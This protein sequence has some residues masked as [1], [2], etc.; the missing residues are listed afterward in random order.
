MARKETSKWWWRW[1]SP[2]MRPFRFTSSHCTLQL[3]GVT[4]DIIAGHKPDSCGRRARGITPA[5]QAFVPSPLDAKPAAP[6]PWR[7]DAHEYLYLPSTDYCRRST[8]PTTFADPPTAKQKKSIKLTS[9]ELH[10][11]NLKDGKNE[12]EFTVITKLQGKA[13]VRVCVIVSFSRGAGAV[14]C[15]YVRGIGK[16]RLPFLARL[17]TCRHH[18]HPAQTLTTHH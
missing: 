16:P 3:I 4:G 17:H 14:P 13:A 5:I 1:S 9:A 10:K 8:A 12:I 18:T 2:P 6:E 11:L 15:V 7:S